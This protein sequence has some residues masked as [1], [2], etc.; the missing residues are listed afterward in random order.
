M[1]VYITHVSI[2]DILLLA[3]YVLACSQAVLVFWTQVAS[4]M[5]DPLS[6]ST[7]RSCELSATKEAVA[8]FLT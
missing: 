5:E 6:A 8:V 4:S 7:C 3:C 2:A 1:Y